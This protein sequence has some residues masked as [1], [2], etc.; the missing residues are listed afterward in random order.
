MILHFSL[1]STLPPGHH[2][3]MLLH[4]PFPSNSATSFRL[5]SCL[6]RS[7]ENA[8]AGAAAAAAGNS[9]PDHPVL[10]THN[11][12]STSL[13]RRH[14]SPQAPE[15]SPIPNQLDIPPQDRI[16]LLETSL[17]AKRR[18][19]FPGSIYAGSP[20][21]ADGGASSRPPLRTLFRDGTD[22]DGGGDVGDEEMIVRAIEIRRK[23]TAEILKEAMRKG[24][25]GITYIDNLVERVPAFIDWVM[26]EA[27]AMKRLPEFV[28]SSFNVRA[29]AVVQ[30]SNFVPLIRWLKHNSLSYPQI[31]KL[32]CM[33]R[34][35]LESIR[36]FAEWLK[37]TNVKGRFVGVALMKAGDN[38]L[39]RG[40]D[41]LDEMVQ[42]LED[43][44]V[45]R[46]WM[47]YVVSRS[48]QLLSY[49]MEEVKSRVAFYLDMGMNE[50]DFGTMVFDYPK[51]LGH[52]TMEEMNQKVHYLKE[53]GL[54]IEEVGKLLAFKPQ[55]MSCS[56]D[57]RWKP[58]VKYLYYLGISRDGMRRMLVIKPMIFCLDLEKVIAPKVLFFRDIGIR[59]DAIGK[60]LVKF[61]PLLTYSLY[62]KIRPVVIFL[63]TK[64][65]VTE[66]NIAKVIALGPE[67][68][69]CSI[70]NKL[71]ISLKYFL[72]LGIRVRQLG[73]MI[74]DFPML[75]RYN[76]D[77]LRPK[78]RYLRR[79]MVRP[80][81]DL[82]EFPR[83]LSYS[84]EGRIIPRHVVL[85]ENRINMKLRYMLAGT[86]EE[87][88]QRVKDAVERRHN[89]ESRVS[90]KN[91]SNSFVPDR[92]L[93]RN[94]VGYTQTEI[95]Y[96]NSQESELFY[97][98]DSVDSSSSDEHRSSSLL[99]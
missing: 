33:S 8:S 3:T 60:M 40:T 20:S 92:Q 13:L 93:E 76:V 11:S 99:H 18:P 54:N 89:F 35:N 56:I 30:D 36:Q 69:G 51:A 1:R 37:S 26:I 80:L 21:D 23:V 98:S 70:A 39:E 22:G 57:D 17:S 71:E 95:T 81:E 55:L 6:H 65:G 38:I 32:I 5:F 75:L 15:P 85:V 50:N 94:A 10:R 86:D 31:G 68:L 29:K 62:K 4:L 58:L 47:G 41:E 42:Y 73:E 49:S 77:I 16:E 46:E 9:S 83:F 52:F 64:A 59:D 25:F 90:S 14:L 44:G 45:R 88:E 66:K 48:P 96:S 74:A 19:Q 27:A 87:F 78:Y 28:E 63:M 97:C 12:K 67:L 61:P 2:Q 84:L 82:I 24:K 53:F 79:T 7:P 43:N 72:S 34:G 91:L